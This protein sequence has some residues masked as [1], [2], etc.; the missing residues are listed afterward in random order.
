MNLLSKAKEKAKEDGASSLVKEGI[1]WVCRRGKKKLFPSLYFRSPI[2]KMEADSGFSYQLKRKEGVKERW[3][4]LAPHLEPDSSI[5]DI[6]CNAGLLTA[7]AAQSGHFAIGIEANEATVHD[8]VEYHGPSR[9]FGLINRRITPENA[10]CLPCFDYV[11]L[12]SIYH[13]LYSYYGRET[14]EKLLQQIARKA[15]DKLF[16]EAA[17]QKSKYNDPQLPFEDFDE[18]S[19]KKYNIRMLNSTIDSDS[20]EYIG[21]SSR[22]EGAKGNRYL[23]VVET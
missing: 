14:S 7:E 19:I 8:A 18:Q 23:F 20:V 10:G 13:Q 22:K 16:F 6:G 9:D 21:K 15:S 3:S 17:A 11:F 1:P 12:F 4:L 5:L 2:V